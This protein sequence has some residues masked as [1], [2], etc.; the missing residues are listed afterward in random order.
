MA[1]PHTLLL[2]TVF[3]SAASVSGQLGMEMKGLCMS[4]GTEFEEHKEALI[5]YDDLKGLFL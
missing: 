4:R 1:M 5:I 3:D 2:E